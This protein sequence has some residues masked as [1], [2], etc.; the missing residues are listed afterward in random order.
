MVPTVSRSWAS[1]DCGDSTSQPRLPATSELLDRES[2]RYCCAGHI[3]KRAVNAACSPHMVRHWFT[4]SES[5][6]LT[7]YCNQD[8]SEC[9]RCGN[10]TTKHAACSTRQIWVA[11]FH[12]GAYRLKRCTTTRSVPLLDHHNPRSWLFSLASNIGYSSPTH[13]AG[14]QPFVECVIQRN[15]GYR[16]WLRWHVYSG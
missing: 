4:A 10:A 1:S 16:T 12:A 3:L 11:E 8:V 14:R 15:G 5:S 6:L 7:A 9:F 2:S 13:V